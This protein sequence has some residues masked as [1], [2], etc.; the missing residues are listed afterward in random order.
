[1]HGFAGI[2]PLEHLRQL[3]HILGKVRVHLPSQSGGASLE[4][5]ARYRATRSGLVPPD[6][7][8]AVDVYT[9]GR[10]DLSMTSDA[11]FREG[12]LIHYPCACVHLFSLYPRERNRLRSRI[13]AAPNCV[14]KLGGMSRSTCPSEGFDFRAQKSKPPDDLV[15]TEH[16]Q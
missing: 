5:V 8:R 10:K 16:A 4:R 14:L 1:M 15:L 7:F 9:H 12:A 3:R 13:V 2:S 6:Y 11:T